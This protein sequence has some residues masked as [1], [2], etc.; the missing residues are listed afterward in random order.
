MFLLV[1]SD[2][3]LIAIIA[4]Y[5]RAEAMAED[6]YRALWSCLICVAVTVAVSLATEPKPFSELKGLVYGA[7][8]IPSEGDLPLLQKPLFWGIAALVVLVTLQIVFW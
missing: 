6:M 5:R 4:L 3:D 2:P 7:T 1:K 8:P